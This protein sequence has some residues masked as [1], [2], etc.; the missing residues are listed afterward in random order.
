MPPEDDRAD[1]LGRQDGCADRH[2]RPARVPPEV[3]VLEPLCIEHRLDVLAEPLPAVVPGLVGT[4]AGALT[5]GIDRDGAVVL[6]ERIE[7]ASVHPVPTVQEQARDQ[8]EPGARAFRLVVDLV[9][10]RDD[11][12]A[13]ALPVAVCPSGDRIRRCCQRPR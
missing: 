8:Y 2:Q 9:P 12:H 3:G 11:E 7:V 6:A 4:V 1:T 10:A 5:Q 13:S